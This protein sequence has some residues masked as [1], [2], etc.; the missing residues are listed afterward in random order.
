MA[1]IIKIIS[2]NIDMMFL[3]SVFLLSYLFANIPNQLENIGHF[4]EAIKKNSKR[5]LQ[6]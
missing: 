6:L 4:N 2:K 5:T 1:F 3:D